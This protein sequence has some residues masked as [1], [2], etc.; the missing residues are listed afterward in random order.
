MNFNSGPKITLSTKL[1]LGQVIILKII[2][3]FLLFLWQNS[4][5]DCKQK[6]AMANSDENGY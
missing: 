2:Q 6:V 1:E 4:V 3:V 5:T